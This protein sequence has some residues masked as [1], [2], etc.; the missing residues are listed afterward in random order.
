MTETTATLAGLRAA[1]E[2]L[3]KDT[4]ED[5]AKDLLRSLKTL[6]VDLSPTQ[7]EDAIGYLK[8]QCSLSKTWLTALKKEIK[9]LHKAPKQAQRVQ[10][11]NLEEVYRLHPAIDFRGGH[12]TLGFRVD[13]KDEGRLRF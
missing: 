12:M 6:L 1:T 5:Q 9:D 8:A 13:L 2:H 7:L 10:M 4:P 11:G 3:T